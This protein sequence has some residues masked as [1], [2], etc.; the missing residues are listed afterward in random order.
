MEKGGIVNIFKYL[1]IWFLPRGK[2]FRCG[3]KI[4][5]PIGKDPRKERKN[6]G[7]NFKQN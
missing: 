3:F 6:N 2:G 7:K 4:T 1:K 5:L